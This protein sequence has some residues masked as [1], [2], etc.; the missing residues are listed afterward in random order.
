M[1]HTLEA[2]LALPALLTIALDE[3]LVDSA[4]WQCSEAIFYGDAWPGDADFDTMGRMV[5]AM[6]RAECER[7]LAFA[8]KAV[9]CC[10]SNARLCT[11]LPGDHRDTYAR[12]G[13]WSVRLSRL[14]NTANARLDALAM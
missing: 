8:R 1:T 10:D 9:E 2:P 13:I 11:H 14:G 4:A 3:I 5:D 12:I 6:G 7:V